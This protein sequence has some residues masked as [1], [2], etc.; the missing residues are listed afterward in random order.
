M[1]SRFCQLH[2]SIYLACSEESKK[3]NNNTLFSGITQEEGNVWKEH[4]RF[5][6][7][8]SKTF[9]FG[10]QESED[11]IHEEVKTL[12]HDLKKEEGQPTDIRY[13]IAYAVNSVV[14]WNLFSKKFVKEKSSFRAIYEGPIHLVEIFADQRFMV[15]GPFFE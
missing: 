11:L 8:T 7:Q 13:H 2:Y 6:L 5:F 3:W 9:G 4:R 14:S 10:K 1:K 15:V 12:I